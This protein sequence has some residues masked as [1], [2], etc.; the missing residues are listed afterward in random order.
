MR[1][2]QCTKLSS[3][4]TVVRKRIKGKC[5]LSFYFIS[6]IS[7]G[8]RAKRKLHSRARAK[9]NSADRCGERERRRRR[10]G[11]FAFYTHLASAGRLTTSGVSRIRPLNDAVRAVRVPSLN[12]V[13]C[14]PLPPKLA[15]PCLRTYKRKAFMRVSRRASEALA[16]Q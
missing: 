6:Y 13:L 2:R 12:L 11:G 10:A 8:E 16:A 9:N 7:S 15:K 1:D 14:R 5:I 3:K 4:V